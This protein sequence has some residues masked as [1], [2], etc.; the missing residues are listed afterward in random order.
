MASKR[1]TCL[2]AAAIKSVDKVTT[3]AETLSRSRSVSAILVQLACNV[4]IGCRKR[5]NNKCLDVC[6][7]AASKL[8]GLS[9]I[10]VGTFSCLL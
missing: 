10:I 5:D 3:L 2:R 1:A 4:R 8:R 7:E 9:E 6:E